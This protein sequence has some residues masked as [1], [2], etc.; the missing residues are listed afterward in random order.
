MATEN[1]DLF[2]D[3]SEEDEDIIE[4]L[5]DDDEDEEDEEDEDTTEDEDDD[6]SDDPKYFS[7]LAFDDDLILDGSGNIVLSE[8]DEAWLFW[9]KKT[10]STP[11]YLCDNYSDDIGIDTEAAFSAKTRDEAEAILR[12][13]ISEALEADPYGRTA[14]VEEISFEWI[15][16]DAVE[17]S[18]TVTGFD[19]MRET[20]QI[21]LSETET[22]DGND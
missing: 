5:E 7:G 6:D 1:E 12:T 3:P 2:P 11:R 13:E 10:L 17:V 15:A 9:C 20:I 4:E 22:G 8:A 16:P 18:A 21:T 19:S 14:T